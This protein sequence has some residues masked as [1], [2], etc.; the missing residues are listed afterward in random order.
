MKKLNQQRKNNLRSI[1]PLTAG[2]RSGILSQAEPQEKVSGNIQMNCSITLL[3]CFLLVSAI[4][5]IKGN[6]L[7]TIMTVALAT[8]EAALIKMFGKT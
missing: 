4:H 7:S 8:M 6:F 2:C 1:N 3:T 5:L